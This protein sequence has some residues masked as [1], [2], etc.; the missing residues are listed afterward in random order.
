[1]RSFYDNMYRWFVSERPQQHVIFRQDF[2]WFD[3]PYWSRDRMD[4]IWKKTFS[5]AVSWMKMFAFRFQSH[6]TLFLRVQLTICRHLIRTGDK[7]YM[8]QWWPRLLTHMSFARPH[9]LHVLANPESK[10]R[11][12]NMGPIWGRQ[13]PSG[14]HVG[15]VN[16]ANWEVTHLTAQLAAMSL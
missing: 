4:A 13:D 9:W 16:F 15:P 3:A 8:N 5:N 10:F 2:A 12:A 14:P 1:M 7:P 11:G 6:W